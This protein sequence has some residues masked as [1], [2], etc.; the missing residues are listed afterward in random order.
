[1]RGSAPA[2]GAF[3]S[4]LLVIAMLGGCAGIEAP[5][6]EGGGS[7]SRTGLLSADGAPAG[8][9]GQDRFGEVVELTGSEV[10]GPA[11]EGAVGAAVV[12]LVRERNEVCVEIDVR[13]LDQP[14]AAHLHEAEPGVAGD[15]V[16][17]LK[18]PTSGEA[19]VDACVSAAPDV[20]H[21]IGDDPS[22]FYL[23]VHSS[24]FPEGALRGQL[25]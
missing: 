9:P 17:A 5:A 14:T 19:S 22:R 15:V 11:D 12:A 7:T 10:P 23:D 1:M 8:R 18:A 24:T 16:L 2:T 3:T 25:R 13:D 6:A 20:L 21:R 4:R